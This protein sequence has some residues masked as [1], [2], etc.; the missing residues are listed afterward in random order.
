MSTH[1]PDFLNGT[2]LDSIFWLTKNQDYTQIYTTTSEQLLKRLVAVGDL[3]GALWTDG[4]FE[5]VHP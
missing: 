5:G 1:S 4:F 3:P 2:H